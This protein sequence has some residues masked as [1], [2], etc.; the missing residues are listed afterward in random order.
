MPDCPEK[1]FFAAAEVFGGDKPV[2]SCMPGEPRPADE[3]HTLDGV[4]PA[5]VATPILSI[6]VYNRLQAAYC[7]A[8]AIDVD[9]RTVEPQGPPSIVEEENIHMT[10][11]SQGTLGS[12]LLYSDASS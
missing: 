6:R 1:E 5:S 2:P 10:S 11:R 12:T 8:L 3:M 7:S 9:G 4:V